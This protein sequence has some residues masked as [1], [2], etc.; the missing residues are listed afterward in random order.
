MLVLLP[1]LTTTIIVTIT[2]KIRVIVAL[3]AIVPEAEA[4]IVRV[5]LLPVVD[6]MH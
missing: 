5:V 4:R 1:T 6:N 3:I 2:D